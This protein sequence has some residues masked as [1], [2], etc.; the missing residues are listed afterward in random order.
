MNT[1]VNGRSANP[2]IVGQRSSSGIDNEYNLRNET[3]DWADRRLDQARAD[4]RADQATMRRSY[5]NDAAMNR[6][7]SRR[8]AYNEQSMGVQ[9]F[10][11]G[12]IQARAD[13][14][15]EQYQNR[16]ARRANQLDYSARMNATGAQSRDNM[17][18]LMSQLAIARGEQGNQERSIFADLAKAKMSNE[19]QRRGDLMGAYSSMSSSYTNPS[20]YKYWS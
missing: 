7:D 3:D 15:S 4:Q 14:R 18:N 17:R 13:R 16:T 12:V 19:T 5:N 2:G 9:Q 11:Q 1:T 10:N 8:A 6:N 20:Q